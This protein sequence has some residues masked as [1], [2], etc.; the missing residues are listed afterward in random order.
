MKHID[1][2]AFNGDSV[3][4]FISYHDIDSIDAYEP[5]TMYE[6]L[7]EAITD[8]YPEVK[9]HA[10]AVW[11]HNGLVKFDKRKDKHSMG[12]TMM[13]NK[14]GYGM[15]IIQPVQ[16]VDILEL[17]PQTDDKVSLKIDAEGAEYDILER[18]I[19]AGKSYQI[20]RLYVEFHGIKMNGDYAKRQ[21]DLIEHFGDRIKFWL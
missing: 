16:C 3:L 21:E 15:G 18:I 13:P 10:M 14:H 20:D 4:H 5:N 6:P 1:I 12:S 9:F 19:E 17:L 7:W 11:L 8:F 2:G